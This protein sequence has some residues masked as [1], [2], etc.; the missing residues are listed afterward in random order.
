MGAAAMASAR[1]SQREYQR[2]V[3]VNCPFDVDYQPLFQAIVFTV[4]D[5]EFRARCALEVEDSG[6]VRASS[7]IHFRNQ[8]I[9]DRRRQPAQ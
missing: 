1:R 6:E 9:T 4:E 2:N 8:P 3:F 5:C 7:P